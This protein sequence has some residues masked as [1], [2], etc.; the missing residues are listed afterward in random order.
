MNAFA[1]RLSI[2]AWLLLNAAAIAQTSS[3]ARTSAPASNDQLSQGAATFDADGPAELEVKKARTGHLLVRPRI[4]GHAPGWFIFDT[5][6]GVCVV[7]RTTV[8]SL[9]LTPNGEIAATGAGG[10]AKAPMYRA[11]ELRLG[12]LRLADHPLMGTDLTF[13]ETH[14]G[15]KV[16]GVIGYG[17]FSRCVATV[18][19]AK[20]SIALHDPAKYTLPRGAWTPLDLSG[21]VPVLTA[22]F[23]GHSGRFMLDTGDHAHISFNEPAVRKWNLLAGREL[24]D[25]KLGGVGGFVAS[26]TGKIARLELGG[27]TLEDVPASFALEAKGTHA[28]T[29]RAGK[30]GAGVLE[31][32][33]LVV[34]Y[35]QERIGLLARE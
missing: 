27:L 2:A 14:L 1:Q 31:R 10:G 23:E 22:T 12:S 18:D 13:L 29:E 6:A 35:G 20:P 34:D 25:G 17:V 8:E 26:K 30:I 32:F 3:P 33:V 24:T 21:R 9:G 4:N 11:D 7:E 15:E 16:R 28:Q 5:G 19:L